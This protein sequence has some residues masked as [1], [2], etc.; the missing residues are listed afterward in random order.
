MGDVGFSPQPALRI[1]VTG[2]RH[3]GAGLLERLRPRVRQTLQSVKVALEGVASSPVAGYKGPPVLLRAVSPLAEGADR[4]FAEEALSLGY[5]LDCPLPFDTDEY[6]KTFEGGEV[7]V[8]AAKRDPPTDELKAALDQAIAESIQC[9][10]DL[11]E[12]RESAFVMDGLN[13]PGGSAYDAVGRV[14]L[15]QSDILLAIWNGQPAAGEG[16]TANILKLARSR[17]IPVLC[18]RTD[19]E[20]DTLLLH[21]DSNDGAILG[22][23]LIEDV[24]KSLTLPPW[25]ADSGADAT[26]AYTSSQA[27]GPSVLGR[28]WNAFEKLLTIG[29][30]RQEEPG[31]DD[32]SKGSEDIFEQY[33]WAINVPAKRLAGLYRGAFL[34]NYVLGVLAVFFALLSYSAPAYGHYWVFAEL[35]AIVIVLVIARN[36]R[37]H[38]W[39]HRTVDCRYLAEQL[40][41]LRHVYPLGLAAPPPRLP[42]HYMQSD[43]KSWME[44]RLRAIVRQTPMPSRKLTS[45]SVEASYNCVL[46]EWIGGQ[47]SYHEGNKRKLELMD[48]RLHWL[49]ER[50]IY[51][52]SIACVGHLFF[53]EA[54]IARWLTFFAAGFPAAAAACHAISTQGEFRRLADRSDSMAQSLRR[55]SEQ[56]ENIR[57]KGQLT[58]ASLR[59]EAKHVA[60]VMLEEVVDWQILYRKPAPP[61]G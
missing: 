36:I 53:H 30:E 52:A 35:A 37:R 45:A 22:S 28:V 25:G 48:H 15:D 13:A 17:H 57:K 51:V 60:D 7:G 38:R 58:G 47:I 8:N 49:G 33:Y 50:F 24:V 59:E 9:F 61:V 29:G 11:F 3:L 56:L 42:A 4:L 10:K 2:H 23:K 5:A 41:I 44:W 32:D 19:S 14:V 46:N 12:K 40:R 27:G 54:A 20:P 39:H 16:G 1:G 43:Q 6:F 31:A 55:V 34:T 26:G 21:G 18:L